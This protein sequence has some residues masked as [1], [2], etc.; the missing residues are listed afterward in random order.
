ML[1]TRFLACAWSPGL[2][3]IDDE[4]VA[5]ELDHVFAVS[6]MR[7]RKTM[8]SPVNRYGGLLWVL[9]IGLV[10]GCLMG[11]TAGLV[12]AVL[13]WFG[14]VGQVSQLSLS[15]F[16]LFSFFYLIFY[17]CVSFQFESNLNS[18]CICRFL[19]VLFQ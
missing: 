17:F 16:Y 13:A 10:L 1:V 5:G 8:P 2:A 19:I 9:A 4:D 15:F 14:L 11:C 6:T 3:F 12:R 18:K 7:R